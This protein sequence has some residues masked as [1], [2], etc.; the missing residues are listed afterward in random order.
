[1][2]SYANVP[3][4]HS[5]AECTPTLGDALF[6]RCGVALLAKIYFLPLVLLI[7]LNYLVFFLNAEVIMSVIPVFL[8]T[9]LL[10]SDSIS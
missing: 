7:Y 4:E 3:L 9:Y 10:I 1:M 8:R 5:R 2:G 6:G